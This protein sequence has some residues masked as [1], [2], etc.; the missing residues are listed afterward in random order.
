MQKVAGPLWRDK[1]A[2]KLANKELLGKVK[3]L[4]DMFPMLDQETLQ[5]VLEENEGDVE[6]TIEVR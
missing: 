4:C 1:K 2:A 5:G 3:K 6:K